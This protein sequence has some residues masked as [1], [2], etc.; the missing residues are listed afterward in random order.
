MKV[1]K[2]TAYTVGKRELRRK[3]E[4]ADRLYHV[5]DRNRDPAFTF[6]AG[7]L[8]CSDP[9]CISADRGLLSFLRIDKGE[10]M[11]I[12]RT[13][14]LFL[15]LLC[16]LL[17]V[18]SV[19]KADEG[20]YTITDYDVKAILH[21]DNTID[22]T[23]RIGVL[24]TEERHGIYRNIPLEMTVV[25]DFSRK[26]DKSEEKIFRYGNKIRDIQV[27]GDEFTA[28]RQGEEE[29]IRI[30]S[31]ER[32][33]SGEKTYV[34]TY[35]YVMPDDRIPYSDFLY[36]SLLGSE[37]DEPINRFT[38]RLMF[39][40]PLTD[41]SLEAF[42]IYSG[43]PGE[44]KNT[45]KVSYEIN[46]YGVSGQAEN[47]GANQVVTVFTNLPRGYF[48][49][50]FRLSAA[51]PETMFGLTTFF[52]LLYLVLSL[53]FR[54]KARFRR[55]AYEPPEGMDSAKA[56]AVYRGSVRFTDLLSLIPYW[57][58]QGYVEIHGR[59]KKTKTKK[60]TEGVR[61]VKKKELPETAPAYEKTMFEALFRDGA[62]EVDTGRL[63]AGFE[64]YLRKA[65]KELEEAF[66]DEKDLGLRKFLDWTF[67]LL[68]CTTFGLFI[69]GSGAVALGDHMI[70]GVFGAAGLFMAWR[71]RQ[72]AKGEE[73]FSDGEAG[74]FLRW[75]IFLF[76][77][78]CILI[79][80]WICTGVDC[81]VSDPYM[82]AAFFFALAAALF[83]GSLF[84]FSAYRSALWKELSAFRNFIRKGE[85]GTL[86]RFLGFDPDYYYRIFPYA[87]ALGL[88]SCWEKNFRSI[89]NRQP[90]WYQV[91]EDD[92]FSARYMERWISEDF[93]SRCQID[94]KSAAAERID[95]LMGGSDDGSGSSTDSAGGGGGVGSW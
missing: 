95:S 32:M 41:A 33:V 15:F 94:N 36:Y 19:S 71:N 87:V 72:K 75:V 45:L 86:E 43:D 44:K 48:K 56:G 70:F 59:K 49:N 73:A 29:V 61:L 53:I 67:M 27:K 54:N 9:D 58:Q 40:K 63:P 23:E 88:A 57:A 17:L 22:V 11:K 2:Q 30:G 20:G 24:F 12:R 14:G 34:L 52:A 55:V 50:A 26:Q 39:E 16:F 8:L 69:G 21:P 7:D 5:L 81:L 4:T 80:V 25:R 31:D 51:F 42:R 64:K 35:T 91:D 6:S 28:S 83:G 3:Y 77:S 85:K 65:L 38:F 60:E 78:F 74:G 79:D 68:V 82:Y 84:H 18:G 1:R 76:W 90:F 37:T 10:I 93:Y 92:P 46:E 13:A 89:R 66:P 47:I 62:E